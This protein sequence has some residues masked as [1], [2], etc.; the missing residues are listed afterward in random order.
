MIAFKTT[1]LTAFLFLL[2]LT[3]LQAQD[4]Y[5]YT[6]ITYTPR[7]K[8]MEISI[9]GKIYRKIDV[10]KDKIQGD[11][12]VNAALEEI[13]KMTDEGWELFD[14]GNTTFTTTNGPFFYSFTF[15]LRKK[16]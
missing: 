3:G 16:K 5:E 9:N 10:P 14:T 13:N 8:L 7:L 1:F 15:Y 2:L 6:V 4:K 11:G 12:D